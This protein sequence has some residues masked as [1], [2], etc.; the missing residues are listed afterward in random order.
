MVRRQL[1]ARGIKD[2]RVLEAMRKVPRHEFVFGRHSLFAYADMPLPIGQGQTISQP[3]MVALM[4]QCLKV[5]PTDVVLDIGA[6]SGYQSAIFAS[7]AQRVWSLE[8][9]PKLARRAR[10]RLRSLGYVNVNVRECDGSLGF[11]GQAPYDAIC[12]AAGA[13]NVPPPLLDQLADG[14]RLAIPVG[15]AYSQELLLITRTGDRFSSRS[16]SQCAF[17]PLLGERG[18]TEHEFETSRAMA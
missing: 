10:Q 6:G 14:G 15:P 16:Y 8:L 3:F 2:P 1:A 13:P 9:L 5:E 12:V 7:L 18:W 11:A 4:T 17:V